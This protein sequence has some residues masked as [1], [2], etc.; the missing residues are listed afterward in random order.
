MSRLYPFIHKILTAQWRW[1]KMICCDSSCQ[2]P[3]N[4][5]GPRAVYIVRTQP[6]LNMS[7]RYL[8]IKRSQCRR[9]RGGRITMHQYHIGQNS[10]QYIS[11]TYQYPACHIIQV[12]PLFHDIQVIIGV[13][14]KN[15]QYLIQ[16]LSMLPSH[17]YNCLKIIWILL[18]FLNQ[19][20][21][22]NCLRSCPKYQ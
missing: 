6:G 1:S 8:L 11:Q 7:Y 10:L 20:S 19:R 12:L 5:F 18:K 15:L 14:L 22:L 16:H 13:Y 3:V 21:H 17:T 4:L 2:L 9:H